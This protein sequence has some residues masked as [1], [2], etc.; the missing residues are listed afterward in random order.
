VAVPKNNAITML[1]GGTAGYRA[2][3]NASIS[4]G[5]VVLSAGYNIVSGGT[6][7]F[8]QV[9]VDPSP[10][11]AIAAN[12]SFTGGAF[13]SDTGA[14]AS[15]FIDAVMPAAGNVLIGTGATGDRY[16]L[17]L[18]A[19]QQISIGAGNGG[20]VRVDGSANLT[21]GDIG[22]NF[23]G[24]GQ[25]VVGGGT[26]LTAGQSIMVNHTNNSG[27]FSIDSAGAINAFAGADFISQPGS[28]I[29]SGSEIFVLAAANISINDVTG[30]DH[31]S[32]TARQNATVNNA[33]LTAS[34]FGNPPLQILVK[35]GDFDGSSYD[36]RYNAALTGN[37]TSV[38]DVVAFAGGTVVVTGP[39]NVRANDLVSFASG[40]DIIIQSG[41]SVTAA[42]NPA[43]PLNPAAP[44]N[45]AARLVLSAG[46]LPVPLVSAPL[47]PIASIVTRGNLNGSNSSVTLTA[48]AIDGLGGT[49]SAGSIQA[50]INNAPSNAVIAATGQ[51]NDNGL[52][53]GQCLQGNICLGRLAATDR[54]EIGQRLS[55]VGASGIPVQAYIE[56]GNVNANVILAT[57]RRNLIIGD[58]LGLASSINGTNQIHL[59]S[60]EGDVAIRN[61][62]LSSNLLQINAASG[63]LTGN[64]NLASAND[65]GVTVGTNFNAGAINTGGQ[66]TTVAGIGGAPEPIYTLPGNIA[67]TSYTQGAV[68]PFQVNAGGGIKFDSITVPGTAVRLK[69]EAMSFWAIAAMRS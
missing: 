19:G 40:D 31:I 51:S 47:S 69:P 38:G 7:A 14:T 8:P 5:E 61:A 48:N 68:V 62:S 67:V 22:F 32:L 11:N 36:P 23:Q 2:A 58:L 43:V 50:D 64:G 35:A 60:I 4:N 20:A 45:N 54:I 59:T 15:G 16:N 52:L 55:A 18:N 10:V 33:I 21:G 1:L 12:V 3:S 44:F 25:F 29:R 27:V 24:S 65:I 63:S 56:G 30:V 66:L 57:T 9:V 41:A 49:I 6:A 26:N 42:F 53:G 28:R 46:T 39:A 37:I 13:T 17:S 34:G